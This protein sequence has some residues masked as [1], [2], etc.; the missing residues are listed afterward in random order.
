MRALPYSSWIFALWLSAI[1]VS[2]FE[3]NS[4][5]WP[6]YT[7]AALPEQG[8]LSSLL[9][10]ALAQQDIPLKIRFLPWNRAVKTAITSPATLGYFPQYQTQ[11]RPVSIQT[12]WAPADWAWLIAAANHSIG[13]N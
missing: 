1:P 3:L 2:A 6:P 11:T 10:G 7:G 5:E 8:Q 13:S 12:A 9:H 4:L